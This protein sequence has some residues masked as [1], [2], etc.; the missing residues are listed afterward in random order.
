MRRRRRMRS[1]ETKRLKKR[2]LIGA[3]A[4]AGH[5]VRPEKCQERRVWGRIG[6][7]FVGCNFAPRMLDR[8]SAW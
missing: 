6:A 4:A 3:N 5:D 2:R 1:R 8:V 7:G